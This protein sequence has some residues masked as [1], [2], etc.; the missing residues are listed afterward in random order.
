MCIYRVG[1]DEARRHA[2]KDPEVQA[3]QL[4]VEPMT[5]WFRAGEVQLFPGPDRDQ[6]VQR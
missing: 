2:A 4:I 6:G 1:L 5:W 3:G